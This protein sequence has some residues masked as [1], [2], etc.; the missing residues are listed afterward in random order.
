MLVSSDGAAELRVSSE[1]VIY[2]MSERRTDSRSSHVS[3]WHP[4]TRGPN[5]GSH[6]KKVGN[7]DSVVQ[8]KGR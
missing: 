2:G 8:Q 6:V 1:I 3:D 7:T 5:F 4:N